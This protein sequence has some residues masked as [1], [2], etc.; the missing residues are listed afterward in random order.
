VIDLVVLP[1]FQKHGHGRT[2]MQSLID[3]AGAHNA[4]LH[5]S[6]GN[7]PFYERLGFRRMRTA[8]ARYADVDGAVAR[9]YV[10]YAPRYADVRVS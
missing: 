6:P 9:G 3:Q 10:E 7:E 8:M 4:M 2:M 5:S 1:E